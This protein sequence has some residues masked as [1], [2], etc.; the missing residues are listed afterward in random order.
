ML[1]PE[2]ILHESA[3]GKLACRPS[4]CRAKTHAGR[5][6]VL[7]SG[8]SLR[9][10]RQTRRT[11]QSPDRCFTRYATDA[12]SAIKIIRQRVASD[13]LTKR[14]RYRLMLSPP[15]FVGVIC[16][17]SFTRRP[18]G[19]RPHTPPSSTDVRAAPSSG[20]N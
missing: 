12:A 7:S 14:S 8:E 20:S 9:P 11:I 10:D 19:L 1:N 17:K 16:S 4:D 3:R 5:L 2:K 15:R 6:P 18:R 13:F